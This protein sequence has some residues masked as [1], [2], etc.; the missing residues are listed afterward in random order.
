MSATGRDPEPPFTPPLR[1]THPATRVLTV[2][3]IAVGVGYALRLWWTSDDAYISFRYARNLV[4]GL[5][6]VYNAGE[7]VEGYSNF[8]WTLWCALG[9][10]LGCAPETWA[11]VSSIAC[12]AATLLLLGVHTRRRASRG[13]PPASG[14]ASVVAAFPW[15]ALIGAAHREWAVVATGGL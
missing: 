12:Y 10:R 7:R 5:G 13:T 14:L 2:L 3:A 4:H 9:L 15:A 1:A 8:L 6:L 11:N